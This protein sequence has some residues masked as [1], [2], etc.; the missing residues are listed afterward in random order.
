MARWRAAWPATRGSMLAALLIVCVAVVQCGGGTPATG[1]T[2]P[3]PL[4]APPGDPPGPT[5]PFPTS[6]SA[7]YVFVGAGDIAMCH[8]LDP[9]IATG[10]LIRDVGGTVFTLGDNAYNHGTEREFREC[11]DKAWGGF[12]D[13]TRPIL[14]NH[15]YEG[16]ASPIPYFRYFGV[17]AGPFQTPGGGYYSH[18]LGEWH[19]IALNSNIPIVPNSDQGKWLEFDV[20][21]HPNKCTI[22]YFHHPLFTSGQNG[23]QKRVALAWR[24]LYDKNVDIILSGHDHLYERFAPQDFEGREDRGR[25]IRQFTVGTGGA[26]LYDFI[27]R[28]PNSEVRLKR[29]G[30]LKLTLRT[31]A[32]DWE[33]LPADGGLPLDAGSGVCH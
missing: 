31:N 2:L 7:P 8:V 14:G 20:L 1:P 30:V 33:F 5:T 11:Y 6:P 25:G 32:Y 3:S 29:F 12:K 4:N 18:E 23:P 13:R 10:R 19:A 9:A 17:N 16:G 27:T 28:A 21:S 26:F 24:Y 15:E 22:A